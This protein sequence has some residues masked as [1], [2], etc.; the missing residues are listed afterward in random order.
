M[1]INEHR[2]CPLQNALFSIL[3]HVSK[4][5]ACYLFLS[6]LVS[7]CFLLKVSLLFIFVC[8]TCFPR[9]GKEKNKKR[10]E[11]TGKGEEKGKEPM[12]HA[13]RGGG[14]ARLF[15]SH[16]REGMRLERTHL[17]PGPFLLHEASHHGR[18]M[19]F[20]AYPLLEGLNHFRRWTKWGR[21]A[22]G[23]KQEEEKVG[24]K[25]LCMYISMKSRENQ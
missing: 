22:M 12:C 11:R 4:C 19:P 20:P 13:S 21:L 8:S 25:H 1:K 15:R 5:L 23:K 16:C 7:E 10:E 18:A 3:P 9:K 2:I 14:G 17:F 24:R 6:L